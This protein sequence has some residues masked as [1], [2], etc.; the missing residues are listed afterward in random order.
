MNNMNNIKTLLLLALMSL[1]CFNAEAQD[2][3][4]TAAIST[5][6]GEILYNTPTANLSNTLSGILPG[7]TVIQ[8]SGQVG[9]DTGKWL[10]RGVGSYGSGN[11]NSSA[12]FVDGFEVTT[13]YILSLSPVEIESVSVLKDA[14]A[15]AIY[16]DRANNGI[17]SIKTKR[18]YAGKPSV[19]A[20]VRYAAQFPTVLNKPLGSYEYANLYNQAVSNDVGE[21]RPKY[22][23]FQMEDIRNG[24]MPNVDWYNEVMSKAGSFVDGNVLFSGGNKSARYNVTFGYLNNQGLL[25]VKNTDN[26]KNLSYQRYNLRANLDFDILNF[27]EAKVDIGARLEFKHRPNYDIGALFYNMNKIPSIAYSVWDDEDKT[28]YSGTAIYPDNPVASINALGWKENKYRMLQGN[29]VLKERL[30][31]LLKGLYVEES[32]SFYSWTASSYSKTRDYARYYNGVQ[33]TTNQNTSITASGYGADGMTDWKQGKI[34]IGYDGKFNKHSVGG[35]LN[36]HISAFHGDGYFEHKEHYVNY[37]GIFDYSYDNRYVAQLAFSV[38]GNDAYAPGKRH[39]FYPSISGAWVLSNESWLKSSAV[40]DFLKIRAS[41]GLSGNSYSSATNAL[42]HLGFDSHGRYLYNRYYTYSRTGSFYM[43]ANGGTWQNTLVPVFIE[44]EYVRPERSLKANIGVDAVLFSAL[45]M[46]ADFFI[47]KRYD[48]LTLDNSMM[49]YFGKQLFLSNVGKMTNAGFE[50]DLAYSGKVGDFSYAIEGSVSYAKNRIDYMAEIPPANDFSAQTGLPYGTFIGLVADGFYDIDDFNPDG[51][52]ID[53]LP[54]PAFGK[55][56]PGDVKYK[57]LDGND[58]ID[59]ND[60]C[61]IGKSWIPELTASLGAKLMFKGFDFS[62]LFQA[63]GNVS[64]NLLDNPHT[65]AFVDNANVFGIAKN[66]W[67][68]Y[69]EQGIDN[70]ATASYPRLTTQGNENNYRTSSMWIVDAGYIKL[71]N[72]EFGYQFKRG[73]RLYVSGQNLLTFSPLKRKYNLDPESPNGYY[74]A[75]RSVSAGVT[76]TF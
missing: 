41:V 47:D 39:H 62:F 76:I 44:N 54:Q 26:T 58:I 45:K 13:D 60:V 71:R 10:I 27:L 28:N 19:N 34:A 50:F 69:P 70:R 72:V 12:V 46:N 16:G 9:G 4:S 75:I 5:V 7:L 20:R 38:F 36:A 1:P 61:K 22:Q 49:G 55:V 15:L 29:F 63:V 65:K 32:F 18:G 11:F 8:G 52:L 30:D 24:Y 48:I 6:S 74:P 25:N 2:T 37:Y 31:V 3:L 73:P 23:D 33:T 21:W 17:I 53:G 43:G 57:N 35:V 68:Y 14:A 64:Y 59:Q 56:V 42:S 51:S 66:A 67:V 40:V